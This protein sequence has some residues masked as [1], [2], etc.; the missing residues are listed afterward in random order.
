MLNFFNVDYRGK[1]INNSNDPGNCVTLCCDNCIGL[2]SGILVGRNC[3][4]TDS[5]IVGRC[6]TCGMYLMYTI[7]FYSE[8]FV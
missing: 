4:T 8:L 7:F 1:I 6:K 2:Q 3:N 5:S